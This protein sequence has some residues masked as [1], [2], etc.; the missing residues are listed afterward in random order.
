M[1]VCLPAYGVQEIGSVSLS[2]SSLVR[3]WLPVGLLGDDFRKLS[4]HSGQSTEP[5]LKRFTHFL[6]EGRPR[7]PRSFSGGVA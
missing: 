2:A 3:K 4:S 1:L 6:R 7:I 5:F